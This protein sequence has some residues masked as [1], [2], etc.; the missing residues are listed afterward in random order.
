MIQNIIRSLL[1]YLSF[2]QNLIS[3]KVSF[4]QKNIMN[5][6]LIM[7]KKNIGFKDI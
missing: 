4:K 2:P 6:V 7:S 3:E 1:T 5:E